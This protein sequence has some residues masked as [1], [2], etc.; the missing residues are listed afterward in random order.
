MGR[1]MSSVGL[2]QV[3]SNLLATVVGWVGFKET[4]MGRFQR[5]MRT[6]WET[7]HFIPE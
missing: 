1:S 5:E 6:R 4:V 7:L 3:G 2:G